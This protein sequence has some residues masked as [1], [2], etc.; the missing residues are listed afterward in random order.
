MYR[1]IGVDPTN[2]IA[3]TVGCAS[4]ASTASLSPC[5]TLNTPSGSPA[6]R[7]S[8]A[9][10][11]ASVGSRSEGFSTNVLPHA[12]A[13]GYIHIGT[14]AGKLNG[15]MP[16]HTPSGCRSEKLSTSVPTF[17]LKSPFSR[18]GIPVTN[19]TTSMPRVT[20]PS[21]SASVLPCSCVMIFASS[22]R[23]ASIASRKRIMMRARRNGGCARQP[24]NAA[25]AL[26][27]AASTSAASAS[28]TCRI[29]SPVAGF[30]ISP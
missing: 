18:C 12:M 25:A 11:S 3:L 6:S 22:L 9:M 7:S 8:S 2:E 19:S 26:A 15:V 28:G 4:S 16:A 29:T 10:R 20:S 27:T 13:T 24:G 5:T 14:I 17:S 21:A 1:A 30:V 23:C